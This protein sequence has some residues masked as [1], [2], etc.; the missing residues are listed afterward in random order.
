M[1][2]PCRWSTRPGLADVRPTKPIM[3]TRQ[4]A[5]PI[6]TPVWRR[7]KTAR[8]AMP[9]SAM[10]APG[11]PITPWKHIQAS[12]DVTGAA[13]VGKRDGRGHV[14]VL[15]QQC[16]ATFR[17]RNH[18]LAFRNYQRFRLR[19]S[20]QRKSRPTRTARAA[21]LASPYQR[22]RRQPPAGLGAAVRRPL[23]AAP[24]GT[25]PDHGGALGLRF[26]NCSCLSRNPGLICA[27]ATGA[28]E[29][30]YG[31]RTRERHSQQGQGRREGSRRQ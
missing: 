18:S 7:I 20:R 31:S 8:A 23:G 13:V 2:A 26:F 10:T 9:L 30:G 28:L 5:G 21:V 24:D 16:G 15:H 14:I 25:L 3:A 29:D 19:G 27:A 17:A 11:G 22:R 4:S 1:V 12:Q 6:S